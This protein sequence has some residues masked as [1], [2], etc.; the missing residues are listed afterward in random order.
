MTSAQSQI[1]E[2]FRALSPDEKE[3]LLP[4]LAESVIDVGVYDDLSAEEIAAIEEGIAQAER[5]ET[6]DGDQLFD[7]LAKKFGFSRV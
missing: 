2:L 6:L 4:Q 7:N 3:S 1:L 5:G